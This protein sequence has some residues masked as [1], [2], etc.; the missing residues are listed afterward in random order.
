MGFFS[1]KVICSVCNK[2][3]GLNRFKLANDGWICPDCFKKCGYTALTPVRNITPEQ[4]KS[5]IEGMLAFV[6]TKKVGNYLEIDENNKKWLAHEGMLGG[7]GGAAVHS[8][9]E[10]VDFEL[11]EDGSVLTK[12]GVG[13]AVVGAAL[14]GGVGAIVGGVT[15]KKSNSVCNSLKIKVTINDMNNPVAYINFFNTQTK[16]DSFVYKTSY[17]FAQ[18]CL[19]V[20]QLICNSNEASKPL[21]PSGTP[22]PSDADE[23][24]KFKY[25]LDAGAITEDEYSLKKKQLLGL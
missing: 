5:R 9:D 23:L 25:L 6:P 16:K 24:L 10:I 15:G 14:F 3:T 21:S 4:A 18:E 20:L 22:A 7:R 1:A 8:F 17:Q 19:S 12:G 13:R 11:L 2:E